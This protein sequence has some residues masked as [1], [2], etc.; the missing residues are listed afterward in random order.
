MNH[1]HKFNNQTYHYEQ[2]DWSIV[3]GWT[4]RLFWSREDTSRVMIPAHTAPMTTPNTM[5]QG[6]V[7]ELTGAASVG[8]MPRNSRVLSDRRKALLIRCLDILLVIEGV[9][10]GPDSTSHLLQVCYLKLYLNLSKY[11]LPCVSH[12][13]HN[14]YCLFNQVFRWMFMF[15]FSL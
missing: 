5:S 7:S 13:K 10:L 14:I 2:K 9:N 11:R 3:K 15:I 4:H 12:C 1:Q 6:G 8:W